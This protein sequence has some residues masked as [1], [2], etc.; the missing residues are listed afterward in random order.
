MTQKPNTELTLEE[1][2]ERFTAHMVKMAGFTHFEDG[3][4]V[5]E[6][7]REVAAAS[8]QDPL[9]RDDGPEAC[10]ESDMHYWGEE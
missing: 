5:E 2:T 8:W 9:Y 7:A 3:G 10:A 1:W 4:S 6:Y